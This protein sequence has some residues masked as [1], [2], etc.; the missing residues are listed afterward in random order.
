MSPLMKK[1]LLLV[2]NYDSGVGYAW[3]LMESFWVKLA[4]QY[5][6]Q[7]QVILAYPSISTLPPAI[8]QAPL[9]V[10][11]QDFN[12]SRFYQVFSQCR[13]LRR[14]KVYTI[15]FS[16]QPTF[17]WRYPLYRLFG[18]RLIV[19]HDH[20]PGLRTPVRGLKAWLKHLAHRVPWL[21][22]DG[23]IG[24]TEFVR[25]RLI[26]VNCVAQSKCFAAPNGLPP[27]DHSLNVVDLHTLFQIPAGRKILIMSGRAHRFKGVDFVLRCMK[28]LLSNDQ[29][30]LH[31]LFL[32][33][34]PDLEFFFDMSSEM[35]IT[36][37]CTFAGRRHDVPDLLGGADI[38][39]HPSRGEVG[40]SLSILEYM[41]AGLPVVVPDNPS[42]CA[43]TE[44]KESG[45]IYAEGNVQAAAEILQQLA[46]DNALRTKLGFRARIEVRKYNLA[47]SHRALLEAFAKIYDRNGVPCLSSEI[48]L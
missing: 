43:A 5:C 37:Y 33:D 10:M 31:F 2:A 4:E 25:Q 26:K 29:K 35:G 12:D 6:R 28:H 1:T 20:T 44:H 24:A 45:M 19:V 32:G 8:V 11:E 47:F 18:V 39:I 22:A 9:L 15:Y 46:N 21:P 36:N 30:K 48:Q 23:F 40:Y 17:H 42:V 3:W 14:N 16:D 38:A 27:L 7:H 41:Q 13:F 34:G